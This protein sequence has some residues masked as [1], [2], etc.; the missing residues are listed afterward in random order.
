MD[1]LWQSEFLPYVLDVRRGLKH[2]GGILAELRQRPT[3]FRAGENLRKLAKLIPAPTPANYRLRMRARSP[4]RLV[5]ETENVAPVRLLLLPLFETGALRAL[6]FFKQEAG[7]VWDY[8]GLTA[9]GVR[10]NRLVEGHTKSFVNRAV[11]ISPLRGGHRT[12]RGHFRRSLIST[13]RTTARVPPPCSMILT[14]P[15]AAAGLRQTLPTSPRRGRFASGGRLVPSRLPIGKSGAH[16][17]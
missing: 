14:K 6:Y 10:A 7:N 4:D 13:D 3:T 16:A 17:G 11:A 9:T 2:L 8:Y 5:L 15:R 12:R 1:A